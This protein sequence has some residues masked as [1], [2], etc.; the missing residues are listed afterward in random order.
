MG[1]DKALLEIGGRPLVEHMLELLRGLGLNPRI[2][3]SRPDLARFAAV[4]PDNFPLCGPLGGIEA[5][6]AAS[7]SN[8]NLFVPVD[9]PGL[10]PSFLQWMIERAGRGGAVATIPHFRDRPQPLC[11]IYSRQLRQGLERFL[12]AGNYKVITAVREAAASVGEVADEFNM[13]SVAATLGPGVWPSHLRMTSW[14]GN[15][16]TPEDYESIAAV[17]GK[18]RHPLSEEER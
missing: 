3:G 10:P 4:V 14:F 9:A 6:L 1:R 13:E 15:V 17:T 11:A 2:C 12:S 5:A 16:N 8:L 18:A 7:D